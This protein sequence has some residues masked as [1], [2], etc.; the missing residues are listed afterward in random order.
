MQN[1]SHGDRTALGETS[2][3]DRIFSA[4]QYPL[5]HY[6][7]SSIAHR[8]MRI[9]KR[10]FKDLQISLF[11]KHYNV[12]MSQSAEK[13]FPSFNA[14]FTRALRD[15]AREISKEGIASP[16][17]GCISQTGPVTEGR[18]LQA[19]GLDFTVDE[20]LADKGLSF[21]SF[22]TIYLSPRDYHRIHMPVDGTLTET[23]H[24]PGR[25]FSVNPA[26]TRAVPR[27]FARN[28]RVIAHFD[29]ELGRMAMVLVGALF[30]SS[31]ETVWQGVVT[32]PRKTSVRRWRGG[33]T[34]T[35]RRG[36]E[37]GRFNMGST[38][39]ILFEKPLT[40]KKSPGDF[41]RLGELLG[42]P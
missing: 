20:L 18:I 12:D 3:S 28:E 40:W 39:I 33:D 7:L 16:V 41:V 14:F 29:T 5:P 4:V 34:V 17:D 8:L 38:V 32:P 22:A 35:L 1:P 26:T 24:I 15:G 19:K 31:I 42:T 25:L 9:R 36:E 13:D 2:R 21:S 23:V 11:I 30:V 37:M 6:F 27:L 10:W